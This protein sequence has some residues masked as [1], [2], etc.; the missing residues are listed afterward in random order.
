MIVVFEAGVF[1]DSEGRDG[2]VTFDNKINWG[3]RCGVV[4]FLLKGQ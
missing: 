3:D 2:E 4:S 1:V